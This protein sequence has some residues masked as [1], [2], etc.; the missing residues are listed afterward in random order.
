LLLAG[1]FAACG[2]NNSSTGATNIAVGST[3]T[4][5]PT[6]ASSSV[7][8]TRLE[9]LVERTIDHGVLIVRLVKHG[10]ADRGGLKPGDIIVKFGSMPVTTEA[11]VLDALENEKPGDRVSITIVNA[12]RKQ[13]TYQVELGEFQVSS[14]G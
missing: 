4:S 5:M 2:Q 10:P 3:I 6:S 11:D 14:N 7:P 9:R 8:T 13:R 1:A 12:A